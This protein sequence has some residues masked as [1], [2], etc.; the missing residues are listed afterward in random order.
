MLGWINLSIEAFIT[1]TFGRA[2][3]NE[4]VALSGVH[5]NWVSSCPYSDKVTYE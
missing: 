2:K 4:V 3:W 1:D 5:T